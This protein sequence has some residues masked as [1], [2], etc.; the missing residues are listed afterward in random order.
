MHLAVLSPTSVKS[1]QHLDNFS[2]CLCFLCKDP[3]LVDDISLVVEVVLVADVVLAQLIVKLI[4]K[5]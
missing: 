3:A 1:S 2:L 5:S 4:V